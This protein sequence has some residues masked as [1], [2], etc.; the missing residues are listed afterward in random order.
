[1]SSSLLFQFSSRQLFWSHW[2]YWIKKPNHIVTC[3]YTI[4]VS[5]I[6]KNVV[7][8][9][10]WVYLDFGRAGSLY[11]QLYWTYHSLLHMR[12]A[13]NSHALHVY[14]KQ[15]NRLITMHLWNYY[16]IVYFQNYNSTHTP[17]GLTCTDE[18]RISVSLVESANNVLGRLS[19][20]YSLAL[21]VYSQCHR[22]RSISYEEALQYIDGNNLTCKQVHAI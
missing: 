8:K 9:H 7:N 16:T 15:L 2:R 17:L 3:I 19:P 4:V 18:S 12:I 10:W 13:V 21:A 22:R 14:K 20:N 6:D 11:L 5:K 1:M